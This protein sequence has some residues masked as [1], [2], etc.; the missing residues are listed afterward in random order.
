MKKLLFVALTLCFTTV[1]FAQTQKGYVKT[2]GRLDNDG[3]LIPGTPL[4]EVVVKVK[5]R[6]EVMSD[7]RGDFSF[8]MPDQT[9]YLES[10]AK[11][12]YVLID[13]DVL[14]KQYN[15]SKNKLVI[16]LETKDQQIEERM[17][18]F[19]KINA[20]Q[21]EMIRKLRAEVKQL[22]EENK[23]TEEEYGRRLQEIADMQMESQQLVE[24][25]VERYSKIDFDQ[26]DDFDRQIKAYILKG[27][28]VKARK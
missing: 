4:S 8:P 28:L 15:Y 24:E 11:N 23:I 10:V 13:P 9:Y 12:G 7:K 22:K 5:D 14:S 27:E 19:A 25:M 18:N 6:N 16:A 3:N 26:M 17:E 1:I 20:A 2:K 21:N